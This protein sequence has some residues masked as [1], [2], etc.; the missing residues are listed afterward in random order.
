MEMRTALIADP[1]EDVAQSLAAALHPDFRIICCSDGLETLAALEQEQPDMLVLELSLPRLDGIGVLRALSAWENRPR[2]LILTYTNTDFVLG[3][4]QELPVD[5]IMRK[6]S[7]AAIVSQ[8]IREILQPRPMNSP[9]WEA[10]DILQSLSIPETS[11]GYRHLLA[12]LPLLA[13]QSE[14]FLGK[15]LYTEIARRNKVSY[16]SVEKAIRDAIRAGWEKGNR[17]TWLQYFPGQSRYP[18]NKLFLT[19]IAGRLCRQRKCG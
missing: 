4:L 12:A 14:Q 17:N 18:Q 3:A 9:E 19:R 5:Y 2:V 8:R 15:I 16:E 13:V 11:Q 1:N 10:A 6:P 7:P